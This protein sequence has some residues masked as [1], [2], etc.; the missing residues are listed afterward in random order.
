MDYV[1][2]LVAISG[3]AADRS[4]VETAVTLADPLNGV[5]HVI[6]VAPLGTQNVWADGFGGAYFAADVIQ[7]INQLNA[8]LLERC[9]SV[10]R[11]VAADHGRAFGAGA[12]GGRV[13]M[14]PMAGT[15]WLALV[16]EAPLADLFVIGDSLARAQ[17]YS[18]GVLAEALM[19]AR[20]PVLVVRSGKSVAGAPV[21]IAWD[22]SLQAGRA[23]RASLPL[24]LSASEV[25][26]L[27]DPHGLNPIEQDSGAPEFLLDELKRRGVE[28][29]SIALVSGGPEG[30]ELL[31]GAETAGAQTLVS[32]AFGHSRIGQTFFG[33][34]TTAFLKAS[35]G[36][37]LLMAH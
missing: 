11:E 9:E 28:T 13:A 27:Q 29:V 25:V 10:A 26:I 17:G 23:V 8:R 36:P 30:P 3:D 18:T 32:G 1:N 4:A 35:D 12:S 7:A 31:K 19:S 20:T 33:G 22:G 5:V 16:R 2:V 37:N 24:L 6:A 21:A 34:A 15:A 14:A